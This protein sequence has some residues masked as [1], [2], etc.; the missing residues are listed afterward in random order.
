M[1]NLVIS[2]GNACECELARSLDGFHGW[3]AVAKRQSETVRSDR[4]HEIHR[5][6][7]AALTIVHT[8][9]EN[10]PRAYV[11]DHRVLDRPRSLREAVRAI[12][13]P[14]GAPVHPA[15]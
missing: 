7:V 8:D 13:P 14:R 6:Y 1:S 3:T 4:P 5:K 2:G 11:E 10:G 12:I 15:V 9:E